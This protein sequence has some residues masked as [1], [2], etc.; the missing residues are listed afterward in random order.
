MRYWFKEPLLHFL[1]IGGLLFSLYAWLDRVPDHEP[2]MIRITAEKVNWLKETW[3]RQ[4]Q[5]P[6]NEEELGGIVTDYLQEELLAHEA[7]ESGLNEN[8]TIVRRRLA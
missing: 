3:I 1:V 4:W 2:R 6:P 5:R 8:D 7:R